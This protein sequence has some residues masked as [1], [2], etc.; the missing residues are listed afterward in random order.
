M[1]HAQKRLYPKDGFAAHVIGYVGEVSENEL[2]TAEFIDYEQGDVVGKQGIERQY[3]KLL[4]G[5]DGQRQVVVDNR[6]K[7]R[8]VFGD[9]EAVP[10][11]NLNLT[12][13]LDVQAVA[14]LAM[15]GRRGSVVALD[16]TQRRSAGDGEPSGVRSES[17]RRPHPCEGLERDHRQSRQADA[18][19]GDSGATRAGIDI[20]AADGAGRT[21]NGC[22]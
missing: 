3:N 20:Q 17:I 4:M 1:I 6:G 2:N 21:R 16:P 10:G 13:D 18:E 8:Q 5:V 12:I 9:K 15:D 14:E 19:P 11:K 7:E 22:R